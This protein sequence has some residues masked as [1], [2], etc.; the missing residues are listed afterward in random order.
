LAENVDYEPQPSSSCIS[1]V[2]LLYFPLET[3]L[4]TKQPKG[5]LDCLV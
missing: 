1:S 5:G 2:L 4:E 3:P